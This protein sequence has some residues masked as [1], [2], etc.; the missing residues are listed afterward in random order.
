MGS[1]GFCV[2]LARSEHRLGRPAANRERLVTLLQDD[3]SLHVY[4]LPLLHGRVHGPRRTNDP[5]H[6]RRRVW[7]CLHL[8]LRCEL[9]AGVHGDFQRAPRLRVL[10]YG[11]S[12]RVPGFRA[13]PLLL[14]TALVRIPMGRVYGKGLSPLHPPDWAICGF[15]LF[16][17]LLYMP[18]P[19]FWQCMSTSR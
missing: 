15:F 10:V 13:V 1:V 19:G 6:S 16:R 18:H 9:Y 2:F 3:P 11:T 8:L 17:Q 12:A 4:G 5:F 7:A 14:S